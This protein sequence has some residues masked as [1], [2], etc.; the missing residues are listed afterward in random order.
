MVFVALFA[1][2]AQKVQNLKIPRHSRIRH[3]TWPDMM[4]TRG[5]TNDAGQASQSD[6]RRDEPELANGGHPASNGPGNDDKQPEVVD[7]TAGHKGKKRAIS[8]DGQG[9]GS[10]G[11]KVLKKSESTDPAA[12]HKQ[13]ILDYV[14]EGLNPLD[15]VDDPHFRAMLRGFAEDNTLVLPDRGAISALVGEKVATAKIRLKDMVRGEA[16]SLTCRSWMPGGETTMM[17]VTAHWVDADWE[18]QSACLAVVKVS[19]SDPPP[20]IY[21]ESEHFPMTEK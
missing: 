7:S 17:A 14:V 15:F 18:L 10:G 4:S 9:S 6:D 21:E 19:T 20:A 1:A 8:E 11:E 16:V 12:A 2:F 5:G 13:L 3:R